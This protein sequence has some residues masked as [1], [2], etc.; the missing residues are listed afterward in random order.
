M[1]FLFLPRPLQ[2]VSLAAREL[3]NPS[4]LCGDRMSVEVPCD[5][6]MGKKDV[7][8]MTVLNLSVLPLLMGK[9]LIES[10]GA[11]GKLEWM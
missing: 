7:L 2:R 8:Q 1:P 9:N 5:L 3:V 4:A 6:R 10:I 11:A